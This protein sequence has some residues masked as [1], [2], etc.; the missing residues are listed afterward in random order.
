MILENEGTYLYIKKKT[1]FK[2]KVGDLIERENK[3]VNSKD[4]VIYKNKLSITVGNAEYIGTITENEYTE[5]ESVIEIEGFKIACNNRDD[6]EAILRSTAEYL[7]N[8]Q[9]N[10]ILS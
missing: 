4:L 2:Y 6:F 9:E 7:L 10:E 1:Y 3:I 5:Y 8:K